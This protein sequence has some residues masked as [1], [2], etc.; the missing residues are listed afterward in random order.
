MEGGLGYWVGNRFHYGHPKY[1]MNATP[2]CYNNQIASPGWNFFGSSS[3]LPD[4]LLGIAQLS[5]RML[6]PPAGLPFKGPPHGE[7]V[8]Y[9][10][11]ALPLTDARSGPQPTGN[12]NWTLFLNTSNFKGPLAYYLP[13]TWS[14]ISHDYTFDHCRGLD[15]RPIRSGLAGSMEINLV[16]Q[17]QSRDASGILYSKIPQLQF[18]IDGQNRTVLVRDVTFYSKEAHLMM[19]SHGETVAKRPLVQSQRVANINLLFGHGL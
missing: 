12:Q 7:L 4:N 6:L 14:R 1:S 3:P 16:P 10:Y 19:L 17:F 11:I 5:N 15:A 8:G 13:E 18:P 9:G 2:D